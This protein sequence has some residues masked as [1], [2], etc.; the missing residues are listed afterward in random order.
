[1]DTLRISFHN[2]KWFRYLSLLIVLCITASCYA[3]FDSR[4]M[5]RNL[6]TQRY[7]IDSTTILDDLDR[8]NVDVFTLVEGTPQVLSTQSSR[9][10]SW[11][12]D[13][14]FRIA[15]ALHQKVW[16]LPIGEQTLFSVTFSIDCSNV[17]QGAFDAAIFRTFQVIQIGEEKT[18]VEYT[19]SIFP[20]NN[21]VRT[22]KLEYYPSLGD[23]KPIDL[24]MYHISAEMALQ[25]AE[26]NGGAENRLEA[27]NAC[28]IDALAPGPD[29]KGWRVIYVNSHN[30]LET[31]YE[32][33]INPETG[34]FNVMNTDH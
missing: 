6:E 19:V 9:L 5:T 17:E 26:R 34:A 24:T 1:M 22:S 27:R 18:R 33:A 31:L 10:V 32:V 28:L 23:Y 3:F 25:I 14:F 29:G 21:E 30:K 12:Q 4:E 13:D 11:S 15:Q 20:S 7:I 8:G 2:N 16:N